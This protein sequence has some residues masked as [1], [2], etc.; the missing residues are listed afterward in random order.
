MILLNVAGLV[1]AA[2][3]A[4]FIARSI[5]RP[6]NTLTS[7]MSQLATGDLSTEVPATERHDEIGKM[8]KALMVFKEALIANKEA[9]AGR[10]RR[11]GRQDAPR[12]AA[13]RDDQ[14][15]RG[16]RFWL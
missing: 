16:Q 5:S 13:R 7:A 10:G 9:E 8:A 1:I 3:L 12:A 6:V 11:G 14:A 2:L 15:V 4:F